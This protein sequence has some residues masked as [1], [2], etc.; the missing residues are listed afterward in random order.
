MS[1]LD[2]IRECNDH[3]L[4]GFVPF[5]VAGARVGWVGPGFADLLRPFDDVFTLD[6][7]RVSLNDALIGYDQRSRAVDVVLRR[8]AGNGQIPVEGNN[9]P[10]G[11]NLIEL[12]RHSDEVL[13]A[14]LLMAGRE[15][16]LAGKLLV[17]GRDKLIEMLEIIDQLQVDNS[18]ADPVP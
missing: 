5:E 14:L 12:V 13:E 15:E 1:F 4:S 11:K 2:R 3:D 10:N 8:L 7:G 6:D 9:S 18:V 16:V 17:D